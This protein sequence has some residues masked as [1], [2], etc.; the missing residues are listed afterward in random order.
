MNWI[1]KVKV[2]RNWFKIDIDD[3]E[4]LNL[5]RKAGT[6][7]YYDQLLKAQEQKKQQGSCGDENMDKLL[8]ALEKGECKVMIGDGQGNRPGQGNDK[9]VEIPDHEWEEFENMPDAEKKLIEKHDFVCFH[10]NS[11]GD[12]HIPNWIF[13]SVPGGKVITEYKHRIDNAVRNKKVFA[14][15]KLGARMITPIVRNWADEDDRIILPEKL[16]SPIP[17]QLK[18]LFFSA[19][20][21]SAYIREDTLSCLLWNNQFPEAFKLYSRETVLNSGILMAKLFKQSLG[22]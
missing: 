6:R 13:M 1:L 7:Y 21:P 11:A 2:G 8:D 9:E 14:W 20:D 5:D 19:G 18:R 3:Y 16:V 15:G 4:H 10:K 17:W 12:N 22:I